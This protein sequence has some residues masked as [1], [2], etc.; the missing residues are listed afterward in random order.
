MSRRKVK[1][2]V[3]PTLYAVMVLSAVMGIMIINS[4]ILKPYTSYDYSKSLMKDVTQATLKETEDTSKKLV[5]PFQEQTVEMKISYYDM[6]DDD[7]RKEKSLILYQNTYMPSSGTFYG[8]SE[9][10]DVLSVMDGKINKINTDDILGTSVEI[11]HNTNLTT[12]YYSLKDLVVKEGDTIKAG[13]PIGKASTNKI[14]EKENNFL[15]EVYYQ[16]KSL[17]P[18]K[19][20][21]MNVDE[22]Q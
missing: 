21:Q 7:E 16:G 8:S 19:F 10:F 1:K 3:L 20:Y 9:E 2:F 5:Q 11:V 15:F 4:M 14:N 12:Y 17:N 22:L 6:A 18:E 13:F